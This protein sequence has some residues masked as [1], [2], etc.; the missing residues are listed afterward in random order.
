MLLTIISLLLLTIYIG[1]AVRV[2]KMAPW[3]LSDTYYQLE[4]RNRPKWLF[5]LAMVVPAFLLLPV[6]LDGSN[7]NLQFLAFLSC[8]GLIFVGAAPC[9]KLE[10]EGKVHYCATAVCGL[11]SVLWTCL[12]GYWYLPVVCLAIAVFLMFRYKKWMF[13]LECALF[14]STYL[15]VIINKI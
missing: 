2:I 15:S 10:L 1:Y 14:V 3:S 11:S 5:Q 6:W 7:E 13:W 4:K 12:S 8:G 9:F